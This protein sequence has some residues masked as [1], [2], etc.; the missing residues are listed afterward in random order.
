M[1]AGSRSGVAPAAPR[2]HS[3]RRRRPTACQALRPLHVGEGEE[4][5]A[6]PH[7]WEEPTGLLGHGAWQPPI[8]AWREEREAT[9]AGAGRSGRESRE[10]GS[11]LRLRRHP[12]LWRSHAA[13][14]ASHEKN[15]HT[16]RRRNPRPMLEMAAT[17]HKVSICRRILSCTY[18]Q[19]EAAGSSASDIHLCAF[20]TST[21]ASAT[22]VLNESHTYGTGR[23]RGSERRAKISVVSN[24][25]RVHSRMR[26]HHRIEKTSRIL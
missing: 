20:Q 14:A 2:R 4:R 17:S 25:P 13:A 6:P 9:E 22:P 12:S 5:G 3:R 15:P 19:L 18:C 8:R 1:G 11:A 26:P 7:A 16:C 21:H 10:A 23:G 24:P